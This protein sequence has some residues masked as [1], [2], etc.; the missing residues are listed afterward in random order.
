MSKRDLLNAENG[1]AVSESEYSDGDI[2]ATKFDLLKT[3][4]RDADVSKSELSD[5]DS[6]VS[7]RD[8]LNAENE[9]ADVSE[10]EYSDG[11]IYATKF[12]LLKTE[13]RD[14]DVSESEYSDGDIYAT[15]FDLLKTE[16][17]DA[18]VSKSELSDRDSNVSKR[19]LLNAENGDAVSESEYSDGDIYATKFDLLK[20]EDR[21]A[22]VSKSELSDRDSN[23]SKRDLLNAEN[24]D[25]DVS[26]SEYSDGDIYA[27]KFDILK[28]EDRD[29]DVSREGDSDGDNDNSDGDVDE[30]E[31]SDGGN[32]VKENQHRNASV[33][34]EDEQTMCNSVENEAQHFDAK[35]DAVSSEDERTI[36]N[37]DVVSEGGFCNENLNDKIYPRPLED[38]GNKREITGV[39]GKEDK[40]DGGLYLNSEKVQK[41]IQNDDDGKK[42]CKEDEDEEIKGDTKILFLVDGK[43]GRIEKVRRW[44]F[45][46]ANDFDATQVTPSDT[47]S[48]CIPVAPCNDSPYKLSDCNNT[49]HHSASNVFPGNSMANDLDDAYNILAKESNV[50]TD[51]TIEEFHLRVFSDECT[52]EK[53]CNYLLTSSSRVQTK[54]KKNVLVRCFNYV[55]KRLKRN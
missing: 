25:A 17:S 28:T 20:T 19:D 14:A 32:D 39:I 49:H 15:K 1:D 11:D 45:D 21:D 52:K 44:L 34:S 12:D 54:K 27:T 6:N 51:S 10:S 37:N 26:E 31:R 48:E 43:I 55:M 38:D 13:D 18:D 46:E 8:L 47:E 24:E 22:D 50:P 41:K 2:Y 9:D 40:S 42:Y 53:I 30:F 7:K 16:D 33:V 29:A 35:I 5:R 4:D 36:V 23:V 3:E